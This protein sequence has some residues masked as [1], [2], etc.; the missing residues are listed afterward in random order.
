MSLYYRLKRRLGYD[1]T[2]EIVHEEPIYEYT[3]THL[4]GEETVDYGNWH[5]RDEGFLIILEKDDDT[6]ARLTFYP[7]SDYTGAPAFYWEKAYDTVRELEGVQEVE[8]EKTGTKRWVF[9]VDK[10][11]NSIV[12]SYTEEKYNE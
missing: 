12:D 2:T 3:V 9:T 5:K 7:D 8:K 1:T 4:N 10:A 6:W 11:D